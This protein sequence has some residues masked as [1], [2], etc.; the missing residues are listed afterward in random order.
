MVKSK[1]PNTAI[2]TVFANLDKLIKAKTKEAVN[3]LHK[4]ITDDIQTATTQLKA[5]LAAIQ[6][7]E[8]E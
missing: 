4:Q 5:E 8:K 7:D 6:K 1:N 2:D 3:K